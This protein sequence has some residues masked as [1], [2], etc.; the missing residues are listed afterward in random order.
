MRALSLISTH[1][2]AT[3]YTV[4][5]NVIFILYLYL[6][7][8]QHHQEHNFIRPSEKSRL[9]YWCF[10]YS[11]VLPMTSAAASAA[12][13]RPFSVEEDHWLEFAASVFGK[14]W[15]GILFLRFSDC[16]RLL[17]CCLSDGK[18][19]KT[20][21]HI[22]VKLHLYILEQRNKHR[23]ILTIWMEHRGITG[24]CLHVR[25]FPTCDVIVH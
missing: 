19:V 21:V 12:R 22:L 13:P 3:V 11:A 6:C 16:S 7:R 2:V 10:T 17:N 5:N 4:F 9:F 23:N 18:R 24:H 8:L 14:E 20:N 25:I 1:V 15:L